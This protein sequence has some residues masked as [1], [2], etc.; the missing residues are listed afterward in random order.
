MVKKLLD[1]VADALVPKEI[2][3][4][5]GTIGTL[6]APVAPGLGLTLG[7]LGSA[8]MYSGKLDPAQALAVGLG[9]YAGGGPQ[10]R[11][12]GKLFGQRLGQGLGSFM[13]PGTTDPRLAD[14]FRSFG[15]GFREGSG[16]VTGEGL[17]DRMLG[18]TARTPEGQA[19]QDR[20]DTYNQEKANLD[21]QFANKEITKS[22]YN[23]ALKTAS[24]GIVDERG[25]MVKAGDVFQKGAE[26]VM[27][28]FTS[29]N[30]ETGLSEFNLGK[31]LT[32]VGTATTLSTLGM[33]AEELKRAKIRDKQEEGKIYTE[34]F[35]S[36]KRV[37]GRDYAQSPYPDP[38]LMEKYREFMMAQG[39]RVGYNMGGGIMDAAPGVP[40]GME[41]D[42]RESGGFIPMGSQEKKDDVPAVLAK[43]EFVLTSDAMT[44]LD[45]MMGGSGDPRAA[46]KYMYQMMDQ[47]EAMA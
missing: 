36:Y 33:A 13:N 31:A 16:P 11:A 25:I 1:K 29:I 34:W 32:T 21:Q 37:S 28:G 40:P 47:L 8:K 9:Y 41:L 24:E 18:T 10:R 22:E 46:A 27:P 45:K 38:V 2:A 39:G 4:Y 5:L 14:R 17:F 26:G 3:P 19:Y 30:P 35:N 42:Y 7:Q 15:A 12:E 43:N 20:L 23:E 6:I 44:G